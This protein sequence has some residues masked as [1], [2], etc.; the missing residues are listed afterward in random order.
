MAASSD[1]GALRS[2]STRGL[3]PPPRERQPYCWDVSRQGGRGK[4][5]ACRSCSQEFHRWELRLSRDSDARSGSGRLSPHPLST[6]GT[7]SPRS[8]H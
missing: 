2:T 7:S 5:A 3:P 8:L 1:G 4:A 6:G